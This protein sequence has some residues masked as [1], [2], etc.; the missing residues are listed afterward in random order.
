M[1]VDTETS[2]HQWTG[3]QKDQGQERCNGQSA[4]T[5]CVFQW[6]EMEI[7]RRPEVQLARQELRMVQND[8]PME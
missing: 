2:S 5:T 3:L 6:Y 7:C 1:I 4:L 8:F